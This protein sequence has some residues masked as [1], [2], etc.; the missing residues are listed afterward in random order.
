METQ[1]VNKGFDSYL[2]EVFQRIPA[3]KLILVDFGEKKSLM[4]FERYDSYT[5]ESSRTRINR[6]YSIPSWD[7]RLPDGRGIKEVTTSCIFG[8]HRLD[9]EKD[10]EFG[11]FLPSSFARDIFL[12]SAYFLEDGTTVA[13]MDPPKVFTDIPAIE[14]KI[15]IIA[16]PKYFLEVITPFLEA[17][18]TMFRVPHWRKKWFR[19]INM[20]TLHARYEKATRELKH[21]SFVYVG[22][23]EEVYLLGIAR[24]DGGSPYMQGTYTTS[25]KPLLYFSNNYLDFTSRWDAEK[26][27]FKGDGLCNVAIYRTYEIAGF[28]DQPFIFPQMGR[29]QDCKNTIFTGEPELITGNIGEALEHFKTTDFAEYIDMVDKYASTI[30]IIHP[31]F[32][33]RYKYFI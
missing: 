15:E 8:T 21:G 5:R 24:E 20:Q 9:F 22:C 17:K 12:E 6:Y 16:R 26:P 14:G 11:I 29:A 25:T 30:E 19:K 23:K 28:D 4:W 18:P 1:A 3:G 31:A 27:K 10:L 32:E 33:R 2:D 13:M 7:R